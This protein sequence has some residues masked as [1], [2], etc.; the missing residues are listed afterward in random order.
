MPADATGFSGDLNSGTG[1]QPVVVT[2]TGSF[3]ATPD[4]QITAESGHKFVII[5]FPAAMVEQ[6]QQGATL[7]GPYSLDFGFQV[8]SQAPVD[9]KAMYTGKVHSGDADYYVPL[10][11]CVTDFAQVPTFTIPIAG[12]GDTDLLAAAI[13]TLQQNQNLV[14]DNTVY[15]LRATGGGND[16][17]MFLPM[18]VH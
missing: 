13:A 14:C 15:D 3:M 18:I 17:P 12:Q 8:T 5:E 4:T 2:E 1:P 9:V 11:P 6:L 10:L 7:N 16:V